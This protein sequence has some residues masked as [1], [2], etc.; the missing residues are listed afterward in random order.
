MDEAELEFRMFKL[1]P[2]KADFQQAIKFLEFL[3]EQ[4]HKVE[5]LSSVGTSK[6][7]HMIQEDKLLW[8]EKYLKNTKLS[9][10]AINL[11]EGSKYKAAFATGLDTI[12][13]DDYTKPGNL[14]TRAG[15]HWINHKTWADTI[16][17]VLELI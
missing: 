5:I 3:Q 8:L 11:V 9:K 10:I 16:P 7:K 4:G 13:I 17:Q 14:F 2:P 12:L 6:T 1:L 15:G